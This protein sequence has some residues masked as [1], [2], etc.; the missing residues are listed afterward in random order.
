[1]KNIISGTVILFMSLH[2]SAQPP[3]GGKGRPPHRGNGD[4]PM[5]TQ[6]DRQQDDMIMGLPDIPDLTLSQREK[7]S[8]EISKER[9][10]ISK[11]MKQRQQIHIDAQNPGM[12]E[13]ERVKL[14]EK[15]IGIDEK[16][17][18]KKQ[19]YNKKYRSILTDEQYRI[20]EVN[21]SKIEF[22]GRPHG[23]IPNGNRPPFPH[24]E[25]EDKHNIH[26]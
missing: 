25:K 26:E 13:K 7:L 17:E 10:D 20:F 12:A 1:M 19:K 22:R 23:K 4:R 14:H 24:P 11:L 16:I 6:T 21:K 15:I 8:K 9:K 2:L 18:K 5:L 3:A